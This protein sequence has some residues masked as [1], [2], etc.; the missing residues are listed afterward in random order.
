MKRGEVIYFYKERE[1]T[2]EHIQSST[3]DFCEWSNVFKTH[4]SKGTKI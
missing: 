2:V 4:K 1:R 3:P